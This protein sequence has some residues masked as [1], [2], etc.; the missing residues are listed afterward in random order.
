MNPVHTPPQPEQRPVTTT[1]HGDQR[2]D[3]YAWLRDRDDEAVLDHLRAENAWTESRLE[4][5]AEQ[6]SSLFDEIRSRIV[7]TDLSVP[8]RRGP[9]WYYSRTKEGLNYPIHCRRRALEHEATPIDPKQD[10]EEVVLYDENLEAKGHDFFSVGILAASPDHLVL[11]ESTDTVGD[12]RYSLSFRRLDGSPNPSESIDNVSYGFAWAE[13]SSTVFYTRVDDAWRPHQLWRHEVG[14]DPAHDVLVLEEPDAR[15]NVG[16]GKTRD[17]EWIVVSISSSTTSETR[18][19][20]ATTPT[21]EPR[22]L[23]ERVD[24][25]EHGVEHH[26]NER[27]ERYWLLVTNAEGA[28]DFKIDIARDDPTMA[29]S[30]APLIA[31]RPG[32]RLDG[33]DAFETALVLSERANAETKLRIIDLTHD[34]SSLEAGRG[35]DLLEASWE[36]TTPERPQSTWLGANPETDLRVLRIGQTSMVTP[37]TVAELDLDTRAISVLKRQEVPGG[38]DPERYVTYLDWATAPD[39]T[40]VPLSI[41]HRR[42]LLAERAAP[43]DEPIAPAPCLLYGYGSYEIS[44]DPT[45]SATRL[46]LLDRGIVFAIA[47]IRGGGEMGRRWYDEG[48][49]AA[50][51]NTFDDFTAVA[52]HLIERGVTSPDRLAARGGS[53]GGLLIGAIANRSPD[54]FGALLGEVPFVDA[55]N[56]MLDPSLPLTIGEYEEWGNP[57]DDPAAYATIKA[58]A[59]YENVAALDADGEARPYPPMLLTGGL[60][61][62]RVGFWEPA[63]LVARLRERVPGVDVLLRMEMGVGHGGPSGRYDSWREEAFVLAWLLEKIGAL[64]LLD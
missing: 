25:V 59:P 20:Q 27:G 14:T 30:F 19:I 18:V 53:A 42:D 39:G 31:H 1:I 16:V 52:D 12:E 6:R 26:V 29:P 24:G 44:I 10:D 17:G 35:G 15:F 45:F 21:E 47:H 57:S 43:G 11:A 7:E 23:V 55:L 33:L 56:T 38:Y 46:V 2:T 40:K 8:V 5:L 4:H 36:V 28:I 9:W 3:A 37:T 48:H 62:T 63:K 32:V 58:Y 13:N 54:R 64:E 41:V 49:L 50:K 61:D 51:H 34:T 60:N 22:V